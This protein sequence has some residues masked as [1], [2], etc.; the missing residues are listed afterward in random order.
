MKKI[1]AHVQ[2]TVTISVV[3]TT[4]QVSVSEETANTPALPTHDAIHSQGMKDEKASDLSGSRK[5]PARRK[6]GVQS[7]RRRTKRKSNGD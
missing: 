4:L 1:V 5:R 3:Q 7:G 6:P 2:R